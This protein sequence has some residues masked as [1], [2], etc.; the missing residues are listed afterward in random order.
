MH[1]F[2]VGGYF[3]VWFCC[4]LVSLSVW[5]SVSL[6]WNIYMTGFRPGGL[7]SGHM[8]E[9]KPLSG[10]IQWPVVQQEAGRPHKVPP[11]SMTSEWLLRG[12]NLCRLQLLWNHDCTGCATPSPYLSA[13]IL[14]PPP[15]SLPWALE[16]WR[17]FLPPPQASRLMD[18][19]LHEE[20]N[21]EQNHLCGHWVKTS[22]H[23]LHGLLF[24]HI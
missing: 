17:Y 9:T 21:S 22:R 1:I 4:C 16:C 20:W 23:R 8:T 11:L 14:F 24:L 13:F 15:C 19:N 5:D 7:L 2:V 18:V 12:P 10:T 3:L 6:A